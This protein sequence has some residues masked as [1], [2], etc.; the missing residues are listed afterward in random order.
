MKA[1]VLYNLGVPCIASVQ[2][3]DESFYQGNEIVFVNPQAVIRYEPG[4]AVVTPPLLYSTF[5]YVDQELA[6][7][8]SQKVFSTKELPLST[9]MLLFENCVILKNEPREKNYRETHVNKPG[10]PTL[11]LVDVTSA[12]NCRCLMCYHI[13]DLDSYTPP[14]EDIEKWIAKLKELGV[15]LIE[16]TGGEPLLRKDLVKILKYILE[17]KLHFYVVTNGEFLANMDSKLVEVLKSGLG[18]GISLDGIGAAHDQIRQNP[19]LYDKLLAGLDFSFKNNLRVYLISTLNKTNFVFVPEMVKIAERYNTTLHVRP[20]IRT[21]NAL[22]NDMGDIDLSVPLKPFL[23]SSHVRNGLLNTKKSIPQS[24]YYGCGIQRRISINS[25][26]VLYPCVM[27]RNKPLGCIENYTIETLVKTLA[28]ETRIL[29]DRHE[30]CRDCKF[31][32]RNDEIPIC[33]G[34]CRFSKSYKKGVK[35]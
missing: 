15:G 26:G 6:D 31:N 2:S 28:A 13:Q 34:F 11:A 5:L 22:S 17:L 16:V 35:Q 33:G 14:L 8:L 24:R 9:L 10:L 4:G 29:L 23:A 32:N 27:D 18:I 7:M 21:G 30:D 25:R 3:G 12:C 19:G 20:T 1:M